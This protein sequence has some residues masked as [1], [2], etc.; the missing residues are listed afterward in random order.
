M[1]NSHN[2]TFYLLNIKTTS[3]YCRKWFVFDTSAS[4]LRNPKNDTNDA[5]FP[6]HTTN[7]VKSFPTQLNSLLQEIRKSSFFDA[8]RPKFRF[9]Q[10]KREENSKTSNS[11]T[12]TY[13]ALHLIRYTLKTIIMSDALVDA[14]KTLNETFVNTTDTDVS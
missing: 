12:Y 10:G 6:Q 13:C 4:E 1:G 7:K 11:S 8:W 5:C 14:F 2:F 3:K 9:A